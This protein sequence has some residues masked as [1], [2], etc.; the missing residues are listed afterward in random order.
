[1][2]AGVAAAPS[3]PNPGLRLRL[4]SVPLAR[5][6]FVWQRAAVCVMGWDARQGG[7]CMECAEGK[8]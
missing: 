2:R 4:R 6:S 1:V 5:S 3:H 8:P 7:E